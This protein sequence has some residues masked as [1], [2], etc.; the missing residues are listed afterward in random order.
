MKLAEALQLRSDVQRRVNQLQD[1]L[2]DNALVQEGEQ[3]AE[4]PT[5]L[6]QEL[7]SCVDQMESLMARINLTNSQVQSGGVTLTQML[8]QRDCLL[9]KIQAYRDFV[10]AASRAAARASHSEIRILSTLPVRQV[11]KKVDAL[12]RRL[13]EL[14]MAIQ[15]MNWTQEL[16]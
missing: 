1:R 10:K 8:S 12:S 4:D 11:Q 16:L 6:F 2:L 3:P 5:E 7:D 9:I 15:Q 14:E 13:R